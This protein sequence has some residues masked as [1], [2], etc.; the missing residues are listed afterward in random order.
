MISREWANKIYDILS[1][2]LDK[3][4]KAANKELAALHQE[5]LETLQQAPQ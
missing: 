1:Q 4:Q 5:W 3:M 2:Q